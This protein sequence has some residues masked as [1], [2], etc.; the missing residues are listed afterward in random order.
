[1]ARSSAPFQVKASPVVQKPKYMAAPKPR[2]A[3]PAPKAPAAVS[4]RERKNDQR[5]VDEPG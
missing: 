1:M 3:A 4:K 5:I 2:E